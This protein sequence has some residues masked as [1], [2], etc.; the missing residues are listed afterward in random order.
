VITGNGDYDGAKD[1]G[2]SI[3][4][5]SS[6]LVLQDW[7]TPFVQ[8][9]LDASDLDLGAGG[10]VVLV[11]LPTSAFPHI[12]IGGGKGT[13]QLGQVYVVNRDSMGQNA[14]P[15]KVVQAFD[16]GGMIY[17]TAALWQTPCTSAE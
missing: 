17:S 8:G 12:L 10:A 2:D 1:F 5:L 15:D 6:S 9:T 11:D 13:N 4:K 3:L 7:F 14:S 16:L